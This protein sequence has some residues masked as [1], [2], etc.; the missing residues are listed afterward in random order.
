MTDFTWYA[1]GDPE[2]RG[3]DDVERRYDRLPARARG[4]VPDV[5]W[6]L[7]RSSSSLFNRFRTNATTIHAR[8]TVAGETLAMAHMPATSV[9]GLDLYGKDT[10]GIW[11]WVGVGQPAVSPGTNEWP[12]AEGLD[13]IE[14]DY[15]LY[16]PLFN[17]LESVEIGLPEGASF[18]RLPPDTRQPIVYYGT[19]IIHGASASR[20]GMALPAQLGRRLD[21]RVIGLGFS[22]N[23]KMEVELAE[24]IAEIDAAVYVIDCLP[25]MEADLIRE[26]TTPFL[27]TLRGLRPHTPILMIEDRTLTN[28][29][30]IPDRRARHDASRRE[31]RAAVDARTDP[32]LHYLEGEHLL[33]VDGEAT[34]DSSHPTD[35]GFTRMADILE[36]ILGK[37]LSS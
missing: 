16:Y 12:I 3:F 9:S 28:A 24:L 30:C 34:V 17:Q 37:L 15:T 21:R 25:N 23:G 35:L 31:Y 2:A 4:R 7:S 36:P 18:E 29:W 6:D 22:G 26:R 11:R 1:L 32:N 14:R 20:N 19:S 13:G 27:D 8:W 10:Q 5:V 33:G